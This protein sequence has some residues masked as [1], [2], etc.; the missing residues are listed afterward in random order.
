M[1]AT[2]VKN[3]EPESELLGITLLTTLELNSQGNHRLLNTL[4]VGALV[5]TMQLNY[6]MYVTVFTKHCQTC[7]EP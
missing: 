7:Q 2:A 1:E 3:S 4:P 6:S 5:S